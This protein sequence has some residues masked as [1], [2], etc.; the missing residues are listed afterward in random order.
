[1]MRKVSASRA[2]IIK[3]VSW[4]AGVNRGDSRKSEKNA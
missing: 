2:D 4:E 1:M 3:G